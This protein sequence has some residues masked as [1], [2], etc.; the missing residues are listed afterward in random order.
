MPDDD[1]GTAPAPP[2]VPQF[3][4]PSL[5]EA[6]VL[7]AITGHVALECDTPPHVNFL[8]DDTAE[9]RTALEKVRARKSKIEPLELFRLRRELRAKMDEVRMPA[10]F[11]IVWSVSPARRRLR[12]ALHGGHGIGDR[13]A[14]PP[15]M[16]CSSPCGN[17]EC[18]CLHGGKRTGSFGRA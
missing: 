16:P 18:A 3:A 15:R 6:N 9:N 2:T 8:F 10:I 14:R 4:I 13:E 17:P 1:N 11:I 5:D 12:T 7:L